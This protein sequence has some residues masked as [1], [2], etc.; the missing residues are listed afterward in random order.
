MRKLLLTSALTLAC[1]RAPEGPPPRPAS[2]P[3]G[4]QWAGGPD[5]GAWVL[6]TRMARDFDCTV[7]HE[8]GDVWEKGRYRAEPPV[9]AGSGPV[10]SAFDGERIYLVSGG[11]LVPTSGK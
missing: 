8:S 1:T 3:A 9:A 5:G 2:V 10:Y 7:F 6:C 11:Q 4:A